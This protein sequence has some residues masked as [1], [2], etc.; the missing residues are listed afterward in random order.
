MFRRQILVPV[1]SSPPPALSCSAG[2]LEGS[3]RPL[4]FL[5]MMRWVRVCAWHLRAAAVWG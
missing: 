5:K 3:L 4:L 1:G 2:D